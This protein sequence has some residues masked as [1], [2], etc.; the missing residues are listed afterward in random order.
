MRSYVPATV[1]CELAHTWLRGAKDD[2][3]TGTARA[4]A[5]SCAIAATND[6]L[7]IRIIDYRIC[8]D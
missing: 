3:A 1:E 8:G 2:V 4:G 7:R 6:R 5:A